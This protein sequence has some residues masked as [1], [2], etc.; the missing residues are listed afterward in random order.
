[1]ARPPIPT[2]TTE[3]TVLRPFVHGDLAELTRIHAEPSFWWYPLRGPMT[4]EDTAGFLDRVIARYESDGFA[5]EALIDRASGEMIGWAG[6]AVPHFL[7]EI[8]P[9]VEVGWRLREASRGDGLA[10]EA[11]GAAV[12]WGFREAGLDRIVSIYEPENQPS[13]RVMEKL[14][15]TYCLT[16]NASP[17]GEKVVVTELTRSEWERR[18]GHG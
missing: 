3:R 4:E 10:T 13:G 1:V 5:V 12:D 8:L 16:T 18:H 7:P 6:L 14:G 2:L 9:A 11:G 17:S 15:F